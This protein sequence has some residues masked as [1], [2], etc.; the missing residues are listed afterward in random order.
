MKTNNSGMEKG[1]VCLTEQQAIAICS[2]LFRGIA[3]NKGKS[4]MK[5]S[6]TCQRALFEP[7]F[8]LLQ[9]FLDK[10]FVIYIFSIVQIKLEK[11][12]HSTL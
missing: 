1:R 11:L 12:F 6:L 2:P 8:E 9:L 7:T 3:T 10:I 4:V 5:K